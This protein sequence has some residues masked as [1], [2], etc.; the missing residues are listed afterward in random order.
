MHIEHASA[1]TSPPPPQYR[2]MPTSG[3]VTA[4]VREAQYS[5]DAQKT[6]VDQPGLEVVPME[7]HKEYIRNDDYPEVVPD[8]PNVRQRQHRRLIWTLIAAVIATGLAI[9]LGVGL[10]L[11][12]RHTR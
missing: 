6:F 1:G 12:L 4:A 10:G 11:G 3:Q 2:A 9:G 7:S 8:E 5:L